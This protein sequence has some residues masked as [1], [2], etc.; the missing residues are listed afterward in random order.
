MADKGCGDSGKVHRGDLQSNGEDGAECFEGVESYKYWD[1]IIHGVDKDWPA[2]L[3]N[4]P[5]S[6]QV[7]GR[8][9]KLMRRER[10]DLIISSKFYRT[11]VQAVLLFGSETWVLMEAMLQ[12]IEGLHVGFLWQVTGM[13][14]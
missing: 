10:A 2:V 12:K 5:R 8:F 1:Q 9:W 13:K 6:R 11:L 4:I 3:H 7:W 14:D